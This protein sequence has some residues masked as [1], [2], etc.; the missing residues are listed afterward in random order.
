MKFFLGNTYRP[1][2]LLTPEVKVNIDLVSTSEKKVRNFFALLQKNTMSCI[3][4]K[5]S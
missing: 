1:L 3:I 2:Y 4:I 5:L